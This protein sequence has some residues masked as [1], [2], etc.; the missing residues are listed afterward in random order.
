M[1]RLNLSYRYNRKKAHNLQEKAFKKNCL[2]LVIANKRWF[3]HENVNLYI[4][5]TLY[6]NGNC[7]FC[8]ARTDL[9]VCKKIGKDIYLKKLKETFEFLK[10]ITPSVSI[11]GGEPSFDEKLPEI[12]DL[13]E[14][15][16]MRK[17]VLNTNA[18]GIVENPELL[19]RINKSSLKHID[20]SRHHFD[21]GK[22]MGIMGNNS[23]ISN[24]RL[25]ELIKCIDKDIRVRLNCNL[26]CGSIESFEDCLKFLDWASSI[27]I[28]NVAFSE[29]SQLMEGDIYAKSAMNFTKRNWIPMIPLLERV[30]K[31][32]KFRFVKQIVG[33]YY[34]VEIW[35]YNGP[36]GDMDV[37]F[38]DAD[39]RRMCEMDYRRDNEN[40]V[41][42]LIFH[43]NG[44]LGGCWNPN[45]KL[46][47]K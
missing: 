26:I 32:N 1:K 17:P 3:V 41:N 39:V 25:K 13:I 14:E 11:V 36:N 19:D 10:P 12:L 35:K 43:P 20:I 4:N 5:P 46:M 31:S 44:I 18:G 8:I 22:N 38:K 21:E 47:S 28:D 30:D 6:C 24:K 16:G 33:P 9:K 23:I 37:V 15:N 2:P 27:G 40:Y 7:E 34:Y 29:L 45:T 42:E